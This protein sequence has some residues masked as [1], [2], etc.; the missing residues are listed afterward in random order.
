MVSNK[1]SEN[2]IY[3]FIWF[4]ILALPVFT[5]Q[6]SGNINWTKVFL[7]WVWIFPFILIFIL[8]NSLLAPNLLF[9]KKNFQY[10]LLLTLSI[11]IIT[12]LSGYTKYIQ[13]YLLPG[14]PQRLGNSS[15]YL[16]HT[17][18]DNRF[19]PARALNKFSLTGRLANNLVLSFL[20]VG[21]NTAVKFVFK[22]QKEDQINEEQKKMHIQTE[23][24]FL[25]QQISPHF[26]MNTLNNIH[27]LVD[28]STEQA[29]E[30]II[31]L[32]EL[33]SYM[34]YE[35]QTENISV[36]KEMNFVKSYV[37]LMRMR[38]TREVDIRLNIPPDLPL[39]SIPPLLSISLIENAF[40]HGISYEDHSFVHINYSFPDHQMIFEIEN[41]VHKV[42]T[43]KTNSGIGIINTRN[44]LNLI[45]SDK[46]KLII[47][48][49]PEKIFSVKLYLPL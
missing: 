20:I 9:K 14:S 31:R 13:E 41:S 12:V 36:Q 49:S 18:P 40:K 10:L 37:E 19:P 44:R 8:N 17:L 2:L 21:F 6:G 45:Y 35:S 29:K 25:R 38:F 47:N 43:N 26:F 39:A 24:S 7:D 15:P 34:L 46:Y 22:R 11:V 48:Q 27:A 32:S 5:T 4:I 23:L 3:V 42:H 16:S 1:R 30:S 33:M 28:I